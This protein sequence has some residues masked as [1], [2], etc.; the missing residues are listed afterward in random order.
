[1]SKQTFLF[2]C[3][4]FAANEHT[5]V[6]QGPFWASLTHRK[7]DPDNVHRL[8]VGNGMVQVELLPSKGLSVGEAEANGTPLFWKPPLKNL[9]DPDWIDL[10][11]ETL[12]NGTPLSGFRWVEGFT[13]G[14]EMLGLENF[15]SPVTDKNGRLL[16]LH[17]DASY[18]PVNKVEVTISE[19]ELVVSGAFEV[20]DGLGNADKVWYR[21][22][23]LQYTVTKTITLKAGSLVIFLLDTITNRSEKSLTPDWGYHIQLH[24][25]EGARLLVP[26]ARSEGRGGEPLPPD[27]EVWHEAKNPGLREE[28]GI[29]HYGL[30]AQADASSRQSVVQTLL[31]YP[32]GTGIRVAAPIAPFFLS[33][34]SCGG[35]GDR[36]ICLPAEDGDPPRTLFQEPW[37]G[38]GPEIGASALDHDGRT[39][40]NV[41]AVT[42]YPG[43]T[44]NLPITIEPVSVEQAE[45]VEQEIRAFQA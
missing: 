2:N 41:Q 23:S 16:G 45:V 7:G 20:Y 10:Y 21:R 13:G 34:F 30:K 40:P 44:L 14:I 12:I 36:T 3:N 33:W 22:G 8:T 37:D 35:K 15:G 4:D 29:I 28:K 18:I 9:P 5:R 11:G 26:A 43:E 31:R 17:G 1:M 42:L 38:V 39:D 24:P 6:E 27:H 25:M 32:D 19:N